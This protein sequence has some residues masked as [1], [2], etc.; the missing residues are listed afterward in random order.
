MLN[1][2]FYGEKQKQ[3]KIKTK[4]IQDAFVTPPPP[5]DKNNNNKIKNTGPAEQ[6]VETWWRCKK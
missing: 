2:L 6:W 4:R 1:V 3:N 5:Q